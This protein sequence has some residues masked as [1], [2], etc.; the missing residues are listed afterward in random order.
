M[1]DMSLVFALSLIW[2]PFSL[3]RSLWVAWMR[4]YLLQD[5]SYWDVKEGNAGSWLWHK[6]LKLRPITYDGSSM[7]L[8]ML[9]LYPSGLTIG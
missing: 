3:S 1:Y 7:R 9:S 6:L 5:I 2:K 8:K 4:K